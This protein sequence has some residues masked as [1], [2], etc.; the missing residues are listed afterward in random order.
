MVPAPATAG[1]KLKNRPQCG[2]FKAR[3]VVAR[4]V[5]NAYKVIGAVHTTISLPRRA[6]SVNIGVAA[7]QPGPRRPISLYTAVEVVSAAGT[8]H[9]KGTL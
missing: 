2:R 5:N 4:L 7:R 8:P 6:A 1:R 9:P 3:G